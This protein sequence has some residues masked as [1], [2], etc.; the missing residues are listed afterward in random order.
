MTSTELDHIPD[1]GVIPMVCMYILCV[2]MQSKIPALDQP[3]VLYIFYST[4][5]AQQKT[6]PKTTPFLPR[7]IYCIYR[8]TSQCLS[9]YGCT[10]TVLYIW[11]FG[12][13]VGRLCIC[14]NYPLQCYSLN[15]CI[16]KQN[17]IGHNDHQ[18]VLFYS[19]TGINQPCY[20][21]YFVHM[22]FRCVC[23]KSVHLSW[24]LYCSIGQ[25]FSLH[26]CIYVA[27]E[28]HLGTYVCWYVY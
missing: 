16:I 18:V 28:I 8:T 26:L 3:T 27:F 1:D 13:N 11:Q 17:L 19:L 2:G 7:R 6:L 15:C 9:S 20:I 14:E 4:V 23:A 12:F 25:W 5:S 21:F 10:I 24:K 22:L